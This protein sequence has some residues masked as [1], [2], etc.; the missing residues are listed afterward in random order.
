[1]RLGNLTPEDVF[2][3]LTKL[4]HV[5]AAGDP[6][7]YLVPDDAL[8]AYMAH[9][10]ARLGDA[11]FRTPRDTVRGFLDLLAL[12]EQHPDVH[13]AALIGKVDLVPAGEAGD[14]ELTSFRL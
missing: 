7:R 8:T 6:S 12:L 13:W 9:C 11:Y 3:L 1:M 4:R 2:V 10:S 14:D 5:F